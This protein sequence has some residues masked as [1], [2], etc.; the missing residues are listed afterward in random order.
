MH[1]WLDILWQARWQGGKL[2]TKLRGKV[3]GLESGGTETFGDITG[4]AIMGLG[5]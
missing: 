5:A 4:W 2:H 1:H 3:H